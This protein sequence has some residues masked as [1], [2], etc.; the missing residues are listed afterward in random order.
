MESFNETKSKKERH[1]IKTISDDECRI[2]GILKG[3]VYCFKN[4]NYNVEISQKVEEM[5]R[6]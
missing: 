4:I 1:N 2:L 5:D 3:C 6:E